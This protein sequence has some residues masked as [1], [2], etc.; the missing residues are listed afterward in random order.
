MRCTSGAAGPPLPDVRPPARI[1]QR[2]EEVDT[3]ALIVDLDAFERNLQLMAQAV[4]GR[5]VRVR[6]HAKTHKCPE[7]ARRQIAAG[8]IGVCCQKVS[9]AEAMVDGGIDNVLISNEVVGAQKLERLAA[10]SQRARLGVCVDD[11]ENLQALA[12]SGA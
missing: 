5:G 3:P 12:A 6:A 4:A 7:I 10:L 2:L 1:G 11:P 8:A 9:E